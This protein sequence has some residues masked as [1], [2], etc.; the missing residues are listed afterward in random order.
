MPVE[1]PGE[2]S[3][4]NSVKM[5]TGGT[6]VT[7]DFP[8]DDEFSEIQGIWWAGIVFVSVVTFAI[9]G[10]LLIAGAYVLSEVGLVNIPY[11]L[12]TALTALLTGV[13]ITVSIKRG[14]MK[15]EPR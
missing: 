6:P 15:Y 11:W 3:L 9:I 12:S 8:T 7:D 14:E 13:L 2:E 10:G 1:M 4:P 5:H